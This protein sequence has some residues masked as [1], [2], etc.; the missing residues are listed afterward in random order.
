MKLICASSRLFGLRCKS[1]WIAL[2]LAIATATATCLLQLGSQEPLWRG[3][4]VTTADIL[5]QTGTGL[6]FLIGFLFP[7]TCL[8][9]ALLSRDFTVQS[10]LQNQDRRTLWRRQVFTAA[11]VAVIFTL[12]WVALSCAASQLQT[13]PLINFDDP[14]SYFF[15]VTQGRTLE[16]L[17]FSFFLFYS[18]AYTVFSFFLTML[19]FLL[20]FWLF[21]GSAAVPILACLLLNLLDTFQIFGIGTAFGIGH[22]HWF[23]NSIYSIAVLCLLSL[24]LILIGWFFVPR[25]DFIH[26]R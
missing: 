7:C 26:A 15:N 17:R 24:A 10:L 8:L 12:L 25:K 19:V 23:T 14:H 13:R 6:P 3:L 4:E 21:S 16:N 1:H 9:A 22:W 5:I 2:C 20:L 18:T 11:A